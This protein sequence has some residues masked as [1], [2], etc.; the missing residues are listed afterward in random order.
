[1]EYGGINFSWLGHASLLV[2]YAEK[3][4][5]IDPYNIGR[6]R[7][8]A[9]YVLITHDHYDHLSIED[10]DTIST[11]DTIIVAP[12]GCRDKLEDLPG[13]LHIIRSGQE[14]DL[15]DFSIHAIP[16]Y[17][18]NKKFHPKENGWVGYVLVCDKTTVYV[19]GDT[20]LTEEIKALA[21]DH[22]IDVAFLPVSGTYVMTPQ[23]AAKAAQALKAKRLVPV[24]YGSIVGDRSH[25]E[26]FKRLVGKNATIL[27]KA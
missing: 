5:Y 16:A 7:P 12:E 19:A 13:T 11:D 25:A 22:D 3:C 10:I 21:E 17:N 20:D 23:E 15:P 6:A 1:M 4:M 27:E 18:T 24:H 14:K 9:D 2:E 8:D 26:E